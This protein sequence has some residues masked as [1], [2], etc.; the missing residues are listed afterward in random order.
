MKLKEVIK[1]RFYQKHLQN[2]TRVAQDFAF[3]DKH[4]ADVFPNQNTINHLFKGLN[5]GDKEFKFN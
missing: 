2:S 3:L 1:N 5:F 4:V